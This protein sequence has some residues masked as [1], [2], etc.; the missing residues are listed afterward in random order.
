MPVV[1]PAEGKDARGM[2]CPMPVGSRGGFV[3]RT[4]AEVGETQLLFYAGV[5]SDEDFVA[6]YN[7]LTMR[8]M[9]ALLAR[10][11]RTPSP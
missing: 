2:P 5:C 3:V 4:A 1:L 8:E 11:R 10:T 9:G 7:A 6:N